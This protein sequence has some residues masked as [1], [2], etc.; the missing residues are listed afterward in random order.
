MERRKFLG[1][2]GGTGLAATAGCLGI[3]T[4]RQNES[5]YTG[6]IVDTEN[7]RGLIFPNTKIHLKTHPTSGTSEEFCITMPED[8]EM[9]ENARVALRDGRRVTVTY[10]RGIFENPWDCFD[11]SSM[12]LDIEV[13]DETAD[14]VDDS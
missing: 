10:Q 7:E 5:D 11:N 1:A 12:V 3:G 6:Y 13:H 9:L 8:E 2:I 4:P 14:D